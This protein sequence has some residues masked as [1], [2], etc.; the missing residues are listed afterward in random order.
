MTTL[1]VNKNKICVYFT[2]FNDASICIS[3]YNCTNE[4]MHIWFCYNIYYATHLQIDVSGRLTDE[5]W[6]IDEASYGRRLDGIHLMAENA[7]RNPFRDGQ[8]CRSLRGS[9]ANNTMQAPTQTELNV[10]SSTAHCMLCWCLTARRD[11]GVM[12][13]LASTLVTT[14][15]CAV[16]HLPIEFVYEVKDAA[17]FGNEPRHAVAQ[18]GSQL[19]KLFR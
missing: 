18:R 19:T 9:W 1:C 2:S 13:D 10:T 16:L 7:G 3:L 5:L 6:C 17:N 12:L 15:L 14:S 8:T 4:N 11:L